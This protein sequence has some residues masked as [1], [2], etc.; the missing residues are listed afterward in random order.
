MKR[1]RYGLTRR[2]ISALEVAKLYHERGLSQQQV[3]TLL[4]IARPTV[5]KLLTHAKESGFIQ[6]SVA[7]PRE[8]DQLLT[9]RIKQ[10]YKLAEVRLVSVAGRGPMDLRHALGRSAAQLLEELV[11]E[12]D[13]IGLSWSATIAEVVQALTPQKIAGMRVVQLR[14]DVPHSS[15][16]HHIEKTY[17]QLAES[18][19]ASVFRLNA[20]AIF[21]SFEEKRAKA[22]ERQVGEVL[23]MGASSRIAVYSVGSTDS[24]S[25]LFDSELM[26][27]REKAQL[28]KSAV[29]DICSRYLNEKGQVCNPELNNRTLGISLPDLRHKE[30]KILV[31]GGEEKLR[32][33]HVAARYGYANRLVTDIATAHRLLQL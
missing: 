15:K 16:S 5:S 23:A 31:A 27:E 18:S 2:D 22:H 20:P 4:H 1:D 12:G 26:T 14:G 25:V 28:R 30:Q 29:G 11:R 33:I 9:E 19:G 32:A 13:V 10:K 17:R 3:A 24:G 6:V 21:C 8:H 7:D